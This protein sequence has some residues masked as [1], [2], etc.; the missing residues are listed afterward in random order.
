MR[1]HLCASLALVHLHHLLGVDG[2]HAVGVDGYT[3]QSGV[4]LQVGMCVCVCVC[5]CV[6]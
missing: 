1:R 5:V 2:E 3:E 4:G 6:C